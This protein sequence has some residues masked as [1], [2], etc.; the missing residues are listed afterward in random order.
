MQQ[1]T[2]VDVPA[3]W[4]YLFSGKEVIQISIKL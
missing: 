2:L 3:G 1:Y 4:I